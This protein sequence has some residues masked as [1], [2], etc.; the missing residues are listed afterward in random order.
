LLDLVEHGPNEDRLTLSMLR[1]DLEAC[2]LPLNRAA[3]R[4]VLSRF[5]A[6]RSRRPRRGSVLARAHSRQRAALRAFG[7]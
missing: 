6:C 1:S 2:L 3:T 4:R 7:R 5:A